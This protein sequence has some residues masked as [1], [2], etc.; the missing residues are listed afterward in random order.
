MRIAVITNAFPPDARGGAGAIAAQ[1][2]DLWRASGED[3]RVWPVCAPWMR[4][5]PFTRLIGHLFLDRRMDHVLRKE[6]LTWHPDVLVTHNLTGSSL[7]TPSAIQAEGVRWI[8]VLHD[9]QLFEPSGQLRSEARAT[10]WQRFWS[11]RRLSVFGH[12]DCVVSPTRW[13]FDAHRRRGWF[14][15]ETHEVIPNPA[16][17]FDAMPIQT[18]QK[19][20][21]ILFVGRLSRDK[22]ANILERI[23]RERPQFQFIF[24]GEG[25][26]K[27]R[28][29][30]YPNVQLLGQCDASEVREQ[31]RQATLLLVPSQIVENQPTV[32]LEAFSVGLPVI[33][34]EIGGIKETM[35]GAGWL[36]SAG[37]SW[38]QAIDRVCLWKTDSTHQRNIE[39]VRQRFARATVLRAWQD[40]WKS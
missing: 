26:Q 35:G 14:L 3:V 28:F 17:E 8:H 34:Q 29:R 10:L 19:E 25:D 23:V 11:W 31:M 37:D 5:N 9:V 20:R 36:I 33:A 27:K 13:L 32:L 22:G 1:L 39:R 7:A 4:A 21:R 2:A 16:P 30:R 24:A 40:V 6:V 15:H 18:K 38:V 12:P